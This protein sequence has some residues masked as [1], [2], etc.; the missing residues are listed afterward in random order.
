MPR[1]Y[2]NYL[3]GQDTLVIQYAGAVGSFASGDKL[4]GT[5]SGATGWFAG[6]LSSP[7]RVI[8]SGPVSGPEQVPFLPSETIQKIGD[9]S[10]RVTVGTSPRAYRIGIGGDSPAQ[11]I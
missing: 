5:R 3:K 7:T 9:S 11:A 6:Y 2:P 8:I 10:R 4:I 1:L